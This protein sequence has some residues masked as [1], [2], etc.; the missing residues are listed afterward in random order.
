MAM[1]ESENYQFTWG[2]TRTGAIDGCA[3]FLLDTERFPLPKRLE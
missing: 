2:I 1:N 3:Y